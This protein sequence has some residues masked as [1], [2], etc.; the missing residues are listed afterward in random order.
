MK[1]S[2]E[3]ELRRREEMVREEE[4]KEVRRFC[5]EIKKKIENFCSH[6]YSFSQPSPFYVFILISVYVC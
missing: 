3:H 6:P 4:K 1:E 2:L 5:F